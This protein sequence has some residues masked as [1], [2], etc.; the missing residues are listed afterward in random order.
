MGDSGLREPHG[1]ARN[2][3]SKNVKKL[4]YVTILHNVNHCNNIW[5]GSFPATLLA[6]RLRSLFAS[7]I[8][9]TSTSVIFSVLISY[10]T[11]ANLL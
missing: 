4:Q 5:H 1:A 8:S 11:A 9:A 7:L 2:I 3:M 6:V 10:F